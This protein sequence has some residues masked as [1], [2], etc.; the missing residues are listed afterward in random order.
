MKSTGTVHF[1]TVNTIEMKG[2]TRCKVAVIFESAN[3]RKFL[4]LFG[5]KAVNLQTSDCAKLEVV[6]V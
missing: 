4:S 1:L 2:L 3:R 5:S 6:V